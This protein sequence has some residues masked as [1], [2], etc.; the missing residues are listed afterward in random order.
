MLLSICKGL[1]A[2]SSIAVFCEGSTISIFE[3][4]LRFPHSN[5]SA[6]QS[7]DILE[8]FK[9]SIQMCYEMIQS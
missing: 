5:C 2:Y 9:S 1:K 6:A 7:F 8:T 3:S 4:E